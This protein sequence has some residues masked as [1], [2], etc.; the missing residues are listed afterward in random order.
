[1]RARLL[2]PLFL[3]QHTNAIRKFGRE[4]M[5]RVRDDPSHP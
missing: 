4:N 1:M 3:L 2:P 5:C